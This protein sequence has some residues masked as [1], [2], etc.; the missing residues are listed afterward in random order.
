MRKLT[1]CLII[2]LALLFHVS[3]QNNAALKLWY[4][5]PAKQWVE[6]LPIGNGGL[7]A[8]VFGDPVKEVIQLNEN[9]VWAGQPNRNDNPQAK[10]ALPEVRRLIFGGKYEEAQSLMNEKFITKTSHGMPYQVV[11]NLKISFD[12]HENY[13]NY[14]R[15]LD[16]EKAVITSRYRVS[17]VNYK[18]E[19]Y[20]SFPD[21][22][23]VV[24]IAA[25]K[26][27]SISFSAS[28]DRPVNA[29]VATRGN[30][31]LLLSGKTSDFEGVEGKVQFQAKVKIQ[32][33]G[34]MVSA[35]ENRFAC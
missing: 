31:Q 15:E 19:A 14:Q 25:D 3:A 18:T 33:N 16:I 24:R 13:T 4:T 21:Q 1:C 11:G 30:D 5:K 8:R 9:T 17:G 28:M 27:G 35:N 22:V 26:P 29:T 7:G 12:G 32:N 10:E 34:G 20:S 6:A 2:H 23:I